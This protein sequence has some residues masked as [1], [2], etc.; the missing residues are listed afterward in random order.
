[1]TEMA[2]QPPQL[3]HLLDMKPTLTLIQFILPEELTH[4]PL[5]LATLQ[6]TFGPL[7]EIAEI[8]LFELRPEGF[9]IFRQS[10]Y[11]PRG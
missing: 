11:T 2:I 8:F 1:M 6:E 9:I 10:T 7:G 3:G 4:S 5:Q